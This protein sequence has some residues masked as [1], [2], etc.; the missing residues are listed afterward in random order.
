MPE[1]GVFSRI[2]T[3][4]ADHWPVLALSVL[5]VAFVVFFSYLAIMK[6]ES[7]QSQGYD[8][9]IYDQAIWNTAQ[10]RL[11][12]YSVWKGKDNWF[13]EPG[14]TLG[15]HVEPILF[16]IVPLY[17]LWA[18]VRILLIVQSLI[19]AL[20]A[21]GIW[22][23]ARWKFGG[24]GNESSVGVTALSG[25]GHLR[26]WAA[27]AVTAAFLFNP[28]LQWAVLDDFHG[29]TLVA[30]L[31]PFALYFMLRQKYRWFLLFAVLIAATKEEMPLLVALMGLYILLFQ[32]WRG[33][34]R[35]RR[36]DALL[37]GSLTFVVG[38]A[39]TATAFFFII[40]HFNNSGASPYLQRYQDI[41]GDEGLNIATLPRAINAIFVMVL[42]GE[43]L[44]YIAALLL[45]TAFLSLF[46]WPL[47]LIGSVSV[48]IN[49]LSDSPIQHLQG[50]HYIAPLIPLVL[51]ATVTGIANLTAYL[52]GDRRR[53]SR[54][55]P[56]RLKDLPASR[57]Y[58]VL[59]LI[60][61]LFT[62]QTQYM[63]GFTPLYRHFEWPIITQRDQLAQ[64]FFEQIPDDASV[65]TLNLLNPHLTHRQEI[66]IIPYDLSGEY[67]LIDVLQQLP[68]WEDVGRRIREGLQ[69]RQAHEFDYG[70]VDA[71]EGYMLLREGASSQT[72]PDEFYD[73]FRVQDPDPEYPAQVDFGDAVRFL[74][75][76]ITEYFEG[77]PTYD[78]YFRT[79]RP[80]DHDYLITLYLANED[81]QIQGALDRPPLVLVWYP[82][83][84]WSFDTGEVI[85][86]SFTNLF[87]LW[88]RKYDTFSMA[89]GV[90]DG[91]DVWDMEQRLTP[92]V[93]NSSQAP[94]LLNKETLFHLLQ[95]RWSN[96]RAVPQP[97]PIL[98]ALPKSATPAAAQYEDLARLEGYKIHTPLVKPGDE[99][100]VELYWRSL[101][102]TNTSYTV[103]FQIMGPDGQIYAQQDNPPALGTMVT[104]RWQPGDLIRD[105]YQ[106]TLADNAPPGEYRILMGFYD[107]ATG[108][109][110]SLQGSSETYFAL[111]GVRVKD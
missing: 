13:A 27:L 106:P 62:L 64:R 10:G 16:F 33:E 6:H 68:N 73:V 90:L 92:T 26:Q 102:P 8:L 7:L 67:I 70:V 57:W 96:S 69:D 94:R 55:M 37:V 12:E 86:I 59:A 60:A 15:T 24:G 78:L 99:V 19:V 72:I 95:L 28:A 82:T 1:S 103:F 23:L 77:E 3:R 11:F 91:T 79:L 85:R 98:T 101:K 39:W 34:N 108:Q 18:D 104:D 36:R 42:N 9:G 14:S 97:D 56:A 75:F 81:Y 88:S 54:L 89:V 74:G 38:I 20:G 53:L 47:L 48:A 46:D 71:A 52:R 21:V 43:T 66:T 83:S 63:R 49:V 58:F 51:A 100:S 5:V 25:P 87:P 45:P 40:P 65:S 29:V 17:W 41:L 111:D 80:L 110:L 76:D 93:L 2:R 44:S 107:L 31:L 109:R 4:L 84:A 35:K 22:L 32:G 30:G 105:V 61:L 50:R